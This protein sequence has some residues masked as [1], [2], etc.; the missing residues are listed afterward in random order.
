MEINTEKDARGLIF[1]PLVSL[2]Q[3]WAP[4]SFAWCVLDYGD[5]IDRSAV[6]KEYLELS[7]VVSQES[8]RVEIHI[9]DVPFRE[10]LSNY[11]L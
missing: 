1:P 11:R 3:L 8:S 4:R 10:Y 2:K 5:H 6:A 7:V 9:N